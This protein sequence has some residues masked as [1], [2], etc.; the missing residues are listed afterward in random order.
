MVAAVSVALRCS[1]FRRNSTTRL[2][3]QCCRRISRTT[4]LRRPPSIRNTEPISKPSTCLAAVEVCIASHAR[5]GRRVMGRCAPARYAQSIRCSSLLRRSVL[6]LVDRMPPSVLAGDNLHRRTQFRLCCRPDAAQPPHRLDPRSLQAAP[7]RSTTHEVTVG[8]PFAR[9]DASGRERVARSR[10]AD[11]LVAP[12]PVGS[13]WV[14]PIAAA[15][16]NSRVD[17]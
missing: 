7:K 12:Q 3:V 4:R 10:R 1:E 13:C 8:A 14:T 16:P 5:P 9:C 6:S 11:R 17:L 2:R 15:R